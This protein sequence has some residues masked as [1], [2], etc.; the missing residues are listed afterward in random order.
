MYCWKDRKR[1]WV[2]GEGLE[3]QLDIR[4]L[5]YHQEIVRHGMS[6]SRRY[7]DKLRNRGY[8]PPGVHYAGTMLR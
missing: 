1:V 3:A 4:Q 5:L 8:P 7:G 2:V 6:C